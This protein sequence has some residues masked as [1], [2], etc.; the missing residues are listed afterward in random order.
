M[1]PYTIRGELKRMKWE[2]LFK[3]AGQQ[4]KRW[5][6]IGA[7]ECR[8]FVE[9]KGFNFC[10]KEVSGQRCS[11]EMASGGKAEDRGR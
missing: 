11:P 2:D 1:N 8:Y 3:L 5:C 9:H 4:K 6:N 10:L 7:S